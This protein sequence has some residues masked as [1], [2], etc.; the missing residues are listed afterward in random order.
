MA[1]EQGGITAA[2]AGHDVIMTPGEF[3]Y[4]DAYQDAPGTQPEAIGGY[5]TLEKFTLTIRFPP[6]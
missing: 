1:G 5:L 3:C 6:N 2:K 4:L